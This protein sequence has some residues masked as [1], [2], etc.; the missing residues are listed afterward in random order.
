MRRNIVFVILLVCLF[1]ISS[2]FS[3]NIVRAPTPKQDFTDI[4][5]EFDKD[6]RTLTVLNIV[7]GGDGPVI[8]KGNATYPLPPLEIGDKI[9]NCSG[10]IIGVYND[11]YLIGEWDFQ[12]N[13]NINITS[14]PYTFI[15]PDVEN[16]KTPGFEI[17][18]VICA[19]ALVIFLKRKRNN[20]QHE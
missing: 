4:R 1:T 15:N 20:G 16:K 5:M 17:I 14:Q 3:F 18:F 19:I 6:N 13:T 11:A 12:G 2:F 7:Y 10:K 8:F 9:T